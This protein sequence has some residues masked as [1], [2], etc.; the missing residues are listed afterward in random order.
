M[1]RYATKEK[2]VQC[3]VCYAWLTERDL[4]KKEH[5]ESCPNCDA[6]ASVD[7]EIVSIL[8]IIRQRRHDNLSNS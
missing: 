2:Q 3:S 6:Y 1:V 7:D 4:I 5:I 8:K